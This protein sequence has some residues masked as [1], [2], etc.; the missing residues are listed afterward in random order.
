MSYI[1]L[2]YFIIAILIFFYF[3]NKKDIL[4]PTNIICAS[5]LLSVFFAFLG[6]GSWN[7]VSVLNIDVIYIY[8]TGL[9]A[10]GVGEVFARRIV[11]KKKIIDNKSHDIVKNNMRIKISIG[12][13]I[14]ASIVVI[15]GIIYL[16][17]DL[18]TICRKS[19][20]ET[21]NLGQML[22]FYRENSNMFNDKSDAVVSFNIISNQ[23]I[24]LNNVICCI[25]MFVFINNIMDKKILQ[26]FIDNIQY[27]FPILLSIIGS[28]FTS[29]RSAL[30]KYVICALMFILYKIYRKN[31][32]MGKI[33]RRRASRKIIKLVILVAI[34]VLPLFYI[35]L[36]L[37]GRKT[38]ASLFDYVTFYLG[39]PA[40]SM[41]IF[42]D[43]YIPKKFSI[44]NGESLIGVY[45]FLD[46]MKLITFNGAKY[47]E[48]T[49]KLG[50]G[51]NVYSSF[52][53]SFVDFGI[54]GVC[55]SHF[56]FGFV[57]TKL[58]HSYKEGK[59]VLGII[60]FSYYASYLFDAMR[61]DAFFT[62]FISFTTIVYLILF[63]ILTKFFI[64]RKYDI[65]DET[66][67]KE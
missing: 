6:V 14:L 5:Y 12:K 9:I 41:S 7:T 48:F 51:S 58:Y 3:V 63:I 49:Y 39:C 18:K 16:F 61:D 28:V 36:P 54:L 34:I 50:L 46:K 37:Y 11:F 62:I 30:V 57:Y 67:L 44:I 56:I 26:G 22:R 10:F 19:G 32:A 13:V 29:G 23:I 40:P 65:I 33:G 15:M 27:L 53:R 1:I 17:W 35:V 60:F 52:R 42:L 31:I 66:C 24:K 25:F 55:I 47:L 20:L 21:N 45:S 64:S 2:I 43:N 59:S 8:I 4:S 38:S